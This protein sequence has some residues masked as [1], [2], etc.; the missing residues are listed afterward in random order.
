MSL[1]GHVFT[2]LKFR[3]MIPDAEAES[4]P[5]WAD[6]DDSRRTRIGAVLRRLNLDELPQLWNV[7]LGEMSLVGPRPE[8]PELIREFR[9][10][11]PGYMLRH[12]V[13]GGLTG[14]AQI[15]GL[16]GNTSLER[17]LALDLEYAERWSL[18]LDLKI[19]V[20]TLVRSFRDPHA[21]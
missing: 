12:K 7:L 10:R 21:Y 13:K 18:W 2:M 1:D 9:K 11:F 3:T 20:L 6:P 4:G 14:L 8:R 5:R 16:R 17:R 19:L 15:N